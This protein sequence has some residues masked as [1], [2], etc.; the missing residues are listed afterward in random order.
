MTLPNPPVS[1][2][3]YAP[4]LQ[5]QID[6]LA[7]NGGSPG[8][9]L[10][11]RPF[12]APT[13]IGSVPVGDV[14]V[15]TASDF[16][17]AKGRGSGM[18][19][20]I[21]YVDEN[22][23][24]GIKGGDGDGGFTP[25]IM[26]NGNFADLGF[27]PIAGAVPDG[28]IIF[29][30]RD[31]KN[32][33]WYYAR[34]E[35][36]T[37]KI[38]IKTRPLSQFP[39]LARS[40]RVK[41]YRADSSSTSGCEAGANGTKLAI[42]TPTYEALT[43]TLTLP[44]F[45]TDVAPGVVPN[46]PEIRYNS[47]AAWRAMTII[48]NA[49]SGRFVAQD[50][51][52]PSA[53][54]GAATPQ[55]RW[56]NLA[57][58]IATTSVQITTL[59]DKMLGTN[60]GGW[61]TDVFSNWEFFNTYQQIIPG[62]PPN[63]N[64]TGGNQI[65]DWFESVENNGKIPASA[66][67]LNGTV[68]RN[69][70]NGIGRNSLGITTYAIRGL[71]DIPAAISAYMQFPAGTAVRTRFGGIDPAN[72]QYNQ[73]TGL[74]T[75]PLQA[76]SNY[77]QIL[78][79]AATIPAGQLCELVIKDAANPTANPIIPLIPPVSKGTRFLD[80]GQHNNVDNKT[81]TLLATPVRTLANR[82]TDGSQTFE[83]QAADLR[84]SGSKFAYGIINSV[85]DDAYVTAFADH[86]ANN[87]PNVQKFFFGLDNE[88]F[89]FIFL[90]YYD[91]RIRGLRAGYGPQGA[92]PTTAV[93]EVI[94]DAQATSLAPIVRMTDANG[95]NGD[96]HIT[97]LRAFNAGDKFHKNVIGGVITFRFKQNVAA[98]FRF[99][100]GAVDIPQVEAF[101]DSEVG[102]RAAARMHGELTARMG[103][104][105]KARFAA[106]GRP[107]PEIVLESQGWGGFAEEALNW[108]DSY[109]DIDR[110]SFAPYFNNDEQGRNGFMDWTD[111][112][113]WTPEAKAKVIAGDY[114]GALTIVFPAFL[115]SVERQGL[116]GVSGAN[117]LRAYNISK[118]DVPDRRKLIGYEYGDHNGFTGYNWPSNANA[119]LFMQFFWQDERYYT[120]YKRYL[121]ALGSI[122]VPMFQYSFQHPAGRPFA[123]LR[124]ST[125]NALSGPNANW[126]YKA[127]K[128]IQ[129]F[130]TTLG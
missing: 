67:G 18:R 44:G 91:A 127:M 62:Y 57:G 90:Q 109:L 124:T 87:L 101:Y 104:I 27:V 102:A 112:T 68:H 106:A 9:A 77:V 48:E 19:V 29:A 113:I 15:D 36:P 8:I 108:K 11:S 70:K 78:I 37:T 98:G 50:V 73:S 22:N 126:P 46:F 33:T 52:V 58:E 117:A 47:S 76:G 65:A 61:G 120:L 40:S 64:D 66:D 74:A 83:G 110:V 97:T 60:G 107:A 1:L 94:M 32:V 55:V 28:H 5:A 4:V 115:L 128:E 81:R 14:I 89:N 93:P 54:D 42:G 86:W 51:G 23:Y 12:V 103:R 16:P 129:D 121:T 125:D 25:F 69:Q 111:A 63:G 116:A 53:F 79:D 92:T 84:A 35:A 118:G 114:A 7:D 95:N 82:R 13:V 122:G 39:N 2:A 43:R 56:N 3:D 99:A 75:F 123:L 24:L 20:A 41:F 119:G 88:I 105:V 96:S 38:F 30:E 21:N 34:P 45:Y 59:F 71:F 130:I 10:V 85:D 72:F 100:K 17:Y 6:N 80:A 49:Q 26:D 31:D